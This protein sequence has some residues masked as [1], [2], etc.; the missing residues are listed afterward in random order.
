MALQQRDDNI[1]LSAARG[2]K[3]RKLLCCAAGACAPGSGRRACRF[4]TSR[5]MAVSYAS[6][7]LG[8]VVVG[9]QVSLAHQ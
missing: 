6:C 8:F 1:L 9:M 5:L 2:G 4:A 3:E 7:I